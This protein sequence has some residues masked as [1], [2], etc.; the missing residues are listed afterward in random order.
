MSGQLLRNLCWWHVAFVA[1]GCSICNHIITPGAIFIIRQLYWIYFIFV[2]AQRSRAIPR[3]N[4]APEVN[5]RSSSRAVY[6]R[7]W[8]LDII[9]FLISARLWVVW[10][11]IFLFITL[12]YT[13]TCN[14]YMCTRMAAHT[15]ITHIS[16]ISSQWSH[17]VSGCTCSPSSILHVDDKHW[18]L[19]MPAL[20]IWIVFSK[21]NQFP[22][23]FPEIFSATNTSII[24]A[25][26]RGWWF[27]YN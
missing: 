25:G 18:F 23:N 8:L 15:Q 27:S 13:Y 22:I 19:S 11:E 17:G 24:A 16:Y 12:K 9:H 14:M 2:K 1:A 26:S 4:E 10:V 21:L 7:A 20:H 3:S 5:H 6:M